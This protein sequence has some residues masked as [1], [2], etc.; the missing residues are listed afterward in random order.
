M[1]VRRIIM[2]KKDI[3]P[4]IRD[5]FKVDSLVNRPQNVGKL[6]KE[7][8]EALN[9]KLFTYKY[10]SCESGLALKFYCA[11]SSENRVVD[12]KIEVFG[13]SEL[14]AVASIAGLIVKN[15][16]PEEILNLKEKGLEYF[17]RENPNTPAF[18]KS[19]R[20]LT[21]VMMDALYQLANAISGNPTDDG[22]VVD[23]YTE[24]PMHIH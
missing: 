5:N 17:L 21:N 22:A 23:N 9:A 19:F 10:G 14:V 20:F 24:I 7:E 3:L 16:K 15:K 2:A 12:C 18:P 4:Q 1:S 8:V 6:T 11:I 13:E